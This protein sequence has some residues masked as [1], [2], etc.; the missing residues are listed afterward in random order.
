MTTSDVHVAMKSGDPFYQN[1]FGFEI[2]FLLNGV[3]HKTKKSSK[4]LRNNFKKGV[5]YFSTNSEITEQKKIAKSRAD[6][7]GHPPNRI[8]IKVVKTVFQPI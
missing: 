5:K 2:H 3:S 1:I 7:Q 8:S 6:L 4:K